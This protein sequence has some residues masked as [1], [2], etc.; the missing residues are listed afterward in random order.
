MQKQA[1]S[2]SELGQT[3]FRIDIAIDKDAVI[4]K[5]GTEKVFMLMLSRF[6]KLTLEPALRSLAECIDNVS[7]DEG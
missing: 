1:N 7:I 6:E 4:K 3:D 2:S 5:K